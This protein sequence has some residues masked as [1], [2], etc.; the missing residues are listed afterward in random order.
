MLAIHLGVYLWDGGGFWFLFLVK[1]FAMNAAKALNIDG[2]GLGLFV[3]RMRRWMRRNP[4][5]PLEAYLDFLTERGWKRWNAQTTHAIVDWYWAEEATK[6][7]TENP[8]QPGDYQ[9]TPRKKAGS[10]KPEA[11]PKPGTLT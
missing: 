2:K 4:G 5:E 7:L 6:G 9:S 11:L 10:S 1:G 8:C 3:A